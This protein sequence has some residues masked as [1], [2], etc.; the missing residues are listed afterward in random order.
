MSRC[1]PLSAPDFHR[2]SLHYW[3]FTYSVPYVRMYFGTDHSTVTMHTKQ[4]SENLCQNHGHF[5]RW[6]SS[7]ILVRIHWTASTKCHDY[8]KVN[9]SML[10][11]IYYL[12][13]TYVVICFLDLKVGKERGM[14]TVDVTWTSTWARITTRYRYWFYYTFIPYNLLLAK[15]F[16]LHMFSIIHWLTFRIKILFSIW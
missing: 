2:R 9:I 13:S 12:L 5:H 10:C 8:N 14:K 15:E 6:C 4:H 1:R 7:F 11:L 16:L 3:L